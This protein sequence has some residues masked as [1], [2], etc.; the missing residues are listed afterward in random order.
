MLT[1]L[2]FLKTRAIYLVGWGLLPFS[3]LFFTLHF[4]LFHFTSLRR[5]DVLVL[6]EKLNFSGTVWVPDYTRHR[7][8]GRHLVFVTFREEGHNPYML[9]VWHDIED[10][11]FISL[12]RFVLD[13]YFRGRRGIIPRRR[14]HDPAARWI[15]A[16][17]AR[18]LGKDPVLLTYH[19]VIYGSEIPEIYRKDVEKLLASRPPDPWTDDWLGYLHHF[20]YFYLQRKLGLKNPSLPAGLSAEAARALAQVRGGDG[21]VRLCGFYLKK[22]SVDGPDGEPNQYD[23]SSF[24]SYLPALRFLVERGYQVLLTGDRALPGPVAEEFNGMVVDGDML[25]DRFGLDPHLYRVYAAMGTDIF[26][27]DAAGGT[28]FAG[29]IADRPMLGLNAFQFC[30]AYGNLWIYYKHAYDHDGNHLSFADMTGKYAFIY[31]L[32][33]FTIEVNTA[34]EILEAVRCYVEEMENPGSSE[35]DHALEDLWPS[36]SGFKVGNCHISPA[37]VRN[38]RRKIAANPGSRPLNKAS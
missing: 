21:S 22:N 27:G 24:E 5:A 26:A 16:H 25:E 15:L 19:K 33:T 17:L 8:P 11:E 29:L 35:I 3:L 32:K 30:S 23:G 1:F 12:P 14:K 37:Y 13:F 28:T 31:E 36:Y 18:W 2:R 7:F 6:P 10:V 34:D 38:Y 20:T 4:L 9:H